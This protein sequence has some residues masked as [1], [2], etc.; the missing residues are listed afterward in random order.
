MRWFTG[1]RPPTREE[2]ALFLRCLKNVPPEYLSSYKDRT[3]ADY[4]TLYTAVYVTVDWLRY[5]FKV[6]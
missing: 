5:K 4:G 2:M 6:K 3:L 1:P